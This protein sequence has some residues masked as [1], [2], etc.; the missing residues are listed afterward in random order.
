MG[1]LG[2]RKRQ[3]GI[4]P[5]GAP[6]EFAF[7]V[8]GDHEVVT[9]SQALVGEFNRG[10]AFRTAARAREGH[11]Q[12]RDVAL[13]VIARRGDQV[14]GGD[15]LD[16]LAREPQQ[17]RRQALAD[18]G[19][20]SGTGQYDAQLLDREQWREKALEPGALRVEQRLRL[21]PGLRLLG[22]FAC[23]MTGAVRFE[24]GHGQI[25]NFHGRHA[26]SSGSIASSAAAMNASAIPV[27]LS[28]CG[29]IPRTASAITAVISGAPALVS[30]ATTIALP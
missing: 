2:K 5:L 23:R 24:E 19:R 29:M 1:E 20:R 7:P 27:S 10:H 11:Q 16:P 21:A 28:G 13:Q 25:Q 22:Y 17:R 14:S 12:G 8:A 26:G 30:G 18:V 9:A 4:V 6:I 15:G 3:P